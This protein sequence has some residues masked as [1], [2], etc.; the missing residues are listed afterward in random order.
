MENLDKRKMESILSK[1]LSVAMRIRRNNIS[2]SLVPDYSQVLI[3]FSHS[4]SCYDVYILMLTDDR[5]L[6]EEL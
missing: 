6:Q 2:N 4:H 5:R 1:V 3:A